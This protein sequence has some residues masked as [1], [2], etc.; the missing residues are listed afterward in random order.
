MMSRVGHE[1]GGAVVSAGSGR[2][3]GILRP[4]IKTRAR[5]RSLAEVYTHEREVQSR[6]DV[7]AYVEDAFTTARFVGKVAEVT[8]RHGLAADT[9]ASVVCRVAG[10]EGR[11][12]VDVKVVEVQDDALELQLG[13]IW[14]QT[15]VPSN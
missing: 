2:L 11:T 9:D 7:E 3:L 4:Q 13:E 15:M 12:A 8:C 1:R 6:S 14:V 10:S 5:V